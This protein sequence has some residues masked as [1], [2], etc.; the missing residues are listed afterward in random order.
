MHMVVL[1]VS[2]LPAWSELYHFACQLLSAQNLQLLACSVFWCHELDFQHSDRGVAKVH[3]RSH[4]KLT[5]F[6]E[7]LGCLGKKQH[8]FWRCDKKISR[9]TSKVDKQ[10]SMK[11]ECNVRNSTIGHF[12]KLITF[13]NR[14]WFLAILYSYSRAECYESLFRLWFLAILYSYSRA[15]CYESLFR[16]SVEI[17]VCLCRTWP[18]HVSCKA[19]MSLVGHIGGTISPASFPKR[20]VSS[21]PNPLLSPGPVFLKNKSTIYFCFLNPVSTTVSRVQICSLKQFQCYTAY[22]PHFF[23]DNFAENA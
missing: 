12:Y 8:H 17:R 16:L 14:L 15:E 22:L 19:F 4:P 9:Y 2:Y 20:S 3:G 21:N 13:R 18:E 1:F 6:Y 5:L 10:K 7:V 23:T 11:A